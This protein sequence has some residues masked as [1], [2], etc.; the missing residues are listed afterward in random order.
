MVHL[1]LLNT[2]STPLYRADQVKIIVHTVTNKVIILGRSV[3]LPKSYFRFE[4]LMEKLFMD[5]RDNNTLSDL[6][7]LRTSSFSAL[8][9]TI[10]P[11]QTIGL[12]R[13]AKNS[14]AQ[15][16]ARRLLEYKDSLLVVGGFPRGHFSGSVKSSL[17]DLYSIH[18]MPLDANVVLGR[19]IYEYEKEVGISH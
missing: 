9:N 14:T 1:S 10:K 5:G 11:S 18:R 2:V 8:I 4:G 12:S 16:V 15:E 19:V 7:E 17:D 13:V 6:L 3:R